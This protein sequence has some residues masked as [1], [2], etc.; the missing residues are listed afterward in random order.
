MGEYG[1]DESG[2]MSQG[3]RGIGEFQRNCLCVIAF[4]AEANNHPAGH[5]LSI[6]DSVNLTTTDAYLS[7]M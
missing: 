1:A 4:V 6:S 2:R 5:L 7:W 3:H